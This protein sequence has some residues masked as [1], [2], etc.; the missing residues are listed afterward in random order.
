MNMDDLGV[1]LFV[2]ICGNLHVTSE[3]FSARSMGWVLA[4]KEAKKER[5][6]SGLGEATGK[7]E[8]RG[9]KPASA[10]YIYGTV[11]LTSKRNN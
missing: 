3:M 4:E 10:S 5:N 6:L 1:P 11:T 8:V 9:T 2:S 7:G